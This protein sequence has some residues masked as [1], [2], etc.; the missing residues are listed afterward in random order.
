MA[1][2]PPS[3]W[4]CTTVLKYHRGTAHVNWQPQD[5]QPYRVLS[6]LNEFVEAASLDVKRYTSKDQTV[7]FHSETKV[8]RQSTADGRTADD[9]FVGETDRERTYPRDQ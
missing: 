2:G 5:C 7:C 4:T 6:D 3:V 9:D 1:N 8:N